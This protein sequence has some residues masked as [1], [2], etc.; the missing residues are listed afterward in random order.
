MDEPTEIIVVDNASTDRTVELVRS[1]FPEVSVL[2]MTSNLGF[3]EAC[4][5][6]IRS[7]SGCYILLLNQDAWLVDES[8][9]NLL[10]VARSGDYALVGPKILN[11]DG[12]V[13]SSRLGIDFLGEPSPPLVSGPFY[14]SGS[15]LLVRKSDYL[16]LG[17]FDRRFFA[18]FEEC[19]LQWRARLLE[20]R[21][22]WTQ[23]A[24][25][26]HIGDEP[27]P[28]GLN[29][30]R[31]DRMGWRRQYLGRRNQLAMLLKNYS[32]AS[33][34]WVL[35]AW[36]GSAA[37]ECAGDLILGTRQQFSVY[38]AAIAWNVRHLPGTL[39]LRTRIQTSR[40]IQDRDLMRRMSPPFRRLHL[41]I[42]FARNA[43]A[44]SREG[45]PK[46]V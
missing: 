5:V 43:K 38:A 44:A 33:L 13:Q 31:L 21:I 27:Q 35:P 42:E 14:L 3:A 4:D 24:N 6:G 10:D 25:A 36:I 32:W 19:D 37:L 34:A 45:H 20:K 16:E 41:C 29:R 1:R 8:L 30:P 18:Y 7:A 9:R 2:A 46:I 15:V 12:T 28:S 26:F 11:P 23:L 39:K 22:G 40:R 17:G